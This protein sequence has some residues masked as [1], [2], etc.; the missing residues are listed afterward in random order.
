[1]YVLL[2]N[3]VTCLIAILGWSTHCAVVVRLSI[4][5]KLANC[6]SV[7]TIRVDVIFGT[8]VQRL[9]PE[10]SVLTYFKAFRV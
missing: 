8:F 7:V 9:L 1:M 5:L 6:R 4:G 2:V 3:S 10:K